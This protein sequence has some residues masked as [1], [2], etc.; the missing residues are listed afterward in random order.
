MENNKTTKVNKPKKVKRKFN[1]K[2]ILG[3]VLTIILVF[4]IMFIFSKTKQDETLPYS[5]TLV[6]RL[7]GSEQGKISSVRP[8]Y[9][10]SQM[11]VN[12][13][14]M[15][16]DFYQIR[17]LIRLGRITDFENLEEEY[18]MQPEFFP[19][20]E[21]IALSLLQNP[22]KDRWGAYGIAV[23]PADWVYVAKPGEKLDVYFY[24]KSGYLV[25]TYQGI[26]L[27]KTFPE[28]AEITTGLEL[29]G[30][31][32]KITQQPENTSQLFDIEINPNPF[33]LEPNFP[34]YK[35]NGTIKVKV[36]VNISEN[37]SQGNYVIA[38]DTTNVPEEYENKWIRD[39]LNLYTSGGMT[40]LDRPYYQLFI[41]IQDEEIGG[42]I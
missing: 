42:D 14:D 27:E 2:L 15:P 22:P 11:F 35:I 38:I 17:Q 10:P 36:S 3:I 12:L 31:I 18:W 33:V 16:E 8:D 9:L 4:A 28:N 23:Y 7:Q 37:I 39:Y 13:P 21:E 29:P 26:N 24:I 6:N 20:F 1:N 34:I 41:Q 25:E 5:E 19:Q 32:K 30:G 40:K